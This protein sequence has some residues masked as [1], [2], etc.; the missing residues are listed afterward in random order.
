MLPSRLQH[1]FCHSSP[2]LSRTSLCLGRGTRSS[3]KLHLHRNGTPNTP[4][5]VQVIQGGEL[6]GG[7][8][9]RWLYRG[10]IQAEF[11]FVSNTCKQCHLSNV[12]L[13]SSSARNPS[14]QANREYDLNS[15][16]I[17]S[18]RHRP[19]MISQ[20]DVFKHLRSRT[21]LEALTHPYRL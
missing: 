20:Y 8:K 9:V 10:K 14:D 5:M 2:R 16:W 7:A 18:R 21:R 4:D 12:K 6:A 3:Q 13:P 15:V 19:S 1:Q 17:S 11:E